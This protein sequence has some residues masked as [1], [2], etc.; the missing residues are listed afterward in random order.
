MH[1]HWEVSL[2]LSSLLHFHVKQFA[3]GKVGVE[4]IM[5]SLTRNDYEPDICF[6]RKEIADTFTPKQLLFPAPD[7]IVEI[8]SDSIVK[9]DRG[10]KKTDYAAHGV[11]EYWIVDPEAKTIEQYILDN[12]T[13]TLKNIMGKE[14][15]LLSEAVKGFMV[16]WGQIF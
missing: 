11:A 5:V 2:N 8:L 14:G 3:I 9:Y 7:F 1:R 13:F 4:K 12:K 16:E 15:N 10:I 6:Y